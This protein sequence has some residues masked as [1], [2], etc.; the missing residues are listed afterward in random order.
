MFCSLPLQAAAREL[1]HYAEEPE[2][3]LHNRYPKNVPPLEEPPVEVEDHH[4]VTE[5][6][7]VHED[8]NRDNVL[9]GAHDEG[10]ADRGQYREHGKDYGGPATAAVAGAGLGA[11]AVAGRGRDRDHDGV[12]DDVERELQ[13][14]ETETG[15]VGGGGYGS[16]Q[17]TPAGGYGATAAT[18]GGAYGRDR[19]DYGHDRDDEDHSS[20][21][22]RGYGTG[23][24]EERHKKGL[25][26]RLKEVFRRPKAAMEVC[27]G[28]D[29]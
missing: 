19:D 25:G 28:V 18:A 17:T 1:A 9:I 26:Q 29:R 16:Q 13:P 2:T 6:E 8:W 14:G 11:A 7:N 27:V 12:R 5:G 4:R 21:E 15:R 22:E 24:R 23:G 10:Y 20:Y 3:L